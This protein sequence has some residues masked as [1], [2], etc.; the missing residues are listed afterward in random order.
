MQHAD[1]STRKSQ[2]TVGLNLLLPGAAATR[3]GDE[4]EEAAGK[5]TCASD[6]TCPLDDA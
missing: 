3:N 2:R 4:E 1:R 5:G 6:A